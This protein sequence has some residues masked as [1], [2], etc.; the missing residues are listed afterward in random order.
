[1]GHFTP[2][3][4]K[5]RFP[6]PSDI[7]IAQE[8]DIKPIS[9][10]A[11]EVGLLSSE[12]ELHGNHK[13]KVELAVLERLKDVPNGKYIDVTAITPTPLG[14]GKSTTMVGLSQ[15]LG[16]HLG[17]RVFTCI[18]QPSQGPT[19]GIKGGAAGGGY[20][21]VIPMEDFNLHLT[22]DIHAITAANNLLAAAID[23]RYFHEASQP[24]DEKLFNALCPPDKQGKRKFSPPMLRRLKRLGIAK[25]DPSDLTKEERAR[26]ARLDIDMDSVSFRRVVD[27]SDRFLRDITIGQGPEE[28]GMTRRTG[29]DIT[30]ASEVMAILALTTDLADMRDRFG[31]MVFGTNKKGEALTAEDL[32]VAGAM[33]V[34][35]KDA[36][37]PNLMQTLEGTPVFVHAGP[38]A[39]IAHGQSSIIADRIA[40]KLA[41][42]VV[43]ESG[44][45]ADIG[46]EKF[47]DVKC[48]TSGLIPNCVVMV[49]TVRALKMHG[50]GPRVVA[51][52]PLA[53]EYTDENLELL[54]AGLGNLQ[55]HIKNARRFGIPVVVAVNSFATDTP[56][57]V[58]LVRQ[59]A[60][61][62]GAEDSVVCTH[63]MEGG[64]G[65]LRLAEAVVK[66]CEKP[67]NFQ[68]LYPLEFS[69]K[70][71]IE[72]ICKEIYGADGVDYLPE[73]EAK[74]ALY[75]RLGFDKLPLCMAKTHLSL[76]H[77]PNIKGV[78]KGY[79]IPIRDI[80]ASV[81][82]GFLYPL[83]G[84]MRTMPGLPTRPV[85]YD[86]DLDLETG[87]VLGLF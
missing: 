40:L 67:V 81:G 87:R 65:A 55:H 83:L 5:L 30:V 32:G 54:R 20:S 49:A 70:Q 19:F 82:A 77:D 63:W 69:I 50:G 61:E 74:I 41:D 31:R 51:G 25:T 68:F 35:M 72:T 66:A 42:Y 8:A 48:R 37:K 17:K 29:F 43:T 44:F 46:M 7:E 86:V 78:P 18:R 22:G 36:I 1:M 58:E 33:T 2:S 12:L 71:K 84:E 21:Q 9:Q 64:K 34:L 39:N 23:A 57:E 6:V 16:A 38:F 79:R 62:A 59:A 73:A 53:A 15:A 3:V 85:F 47:F 75:T 10:V 4:L 80:R 14:E 52:K 56:A 27:T 24:D 13:A 60:I 11:E 28:K 76:S 26:F 45:G